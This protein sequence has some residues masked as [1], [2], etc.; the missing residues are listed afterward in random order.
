MLKQLECLTPEQLQAL[1][2]VESLPDE[3]LV[4]DDNQELLAYL[5]ALPDKLERELALVIREQ[6][7]ML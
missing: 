4:S 7:E 2:K 6:A 1:K 5:N 3:F